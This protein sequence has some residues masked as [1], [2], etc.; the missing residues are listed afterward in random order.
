MNYT[1]ELE[2]IE[3]VERDCIRGDELINGWKPVDTGNSIYWSNQDAT[4]QV[5]FCPAFSEDVS[6]V[7]VVFTNDLT[8]DETSLSCELGP[9]VKD[10]LGVN[11]VVVQDFKKRLLDTIRNLF[12]SL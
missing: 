1:E 4:F 8:G 5:E 12:K 6:K 2:T 11:P 9:C 3:S 7:R 10:R